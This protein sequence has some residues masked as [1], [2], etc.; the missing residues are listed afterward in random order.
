MSAKSRSSSLRQRQMP[1]SSPPAQRSNGKPAP[2]SRESEKTE[3]RGVVYA[4]ATTA[5]SDLTFGMI[6][7]SSRTR[8]RA[9]RLA[10]GGGRD[11]RGAGARR[12]RRL[13]PRAD[14]R[15]RETWRLRRAAARDARAGALHRRLLP[16]RPHVDGGAVRRRVPGGAAAA[17]PRVR[18]HRD[19]RRLA[20]DAL[21]AR[22]AARRRFRVGGGGARARRR[23]RAAGRRRRLR[24]ARVRRAV[25]DR[26][27]PPR[28][29]RAAHARRRRAR[30][31]RRRRRR[32]A[33]DGNGSVVARARR[34]A[35]AALDAHGARRAQL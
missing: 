34:R 25:H 15:A 7:P 24:L 3:W 23:L 21:G 30:R 9:R 35:R 33:V 4:C 28:R 8:A 10:V 5:L 19:R 26:R 13:D 16:R 1:A 6:A 29:A 11:L 17:G 32:P 18:P 2:I 27:R 22:P 12:V 31:Q 14:L 20:R